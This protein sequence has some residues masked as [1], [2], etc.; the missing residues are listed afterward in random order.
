MK[1]FR[2]DHQYLE[3]KMFDFSLL[4]NWSRYCCLDRRIYSI[5]LF[6]SFLNLFHCLG[7]YICLPLLYAR[8]RLHICFRIAVVI[9]GGSDGLILTVLFGINSAVKEFKWLVMLL[10]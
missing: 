7:V 6:L 5:T 4:D 2:V 8:L 10:A 3:D 1:D 9:D